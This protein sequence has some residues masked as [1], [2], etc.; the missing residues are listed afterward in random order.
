MSMNWMPAFAG[1][2]LLALAA[3]ALGGDVLR[4]GNSVE[5]ET[6]DPHAARG[7]SASNIIRDLYEGLTTES[8]AG[9]IAP[10]M[11]ERW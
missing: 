2:T 7:V 1:M 9:A 4:R 11:A 3:P 8:P 6:L 5:P 10:G